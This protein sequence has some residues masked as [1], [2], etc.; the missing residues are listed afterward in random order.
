MAEAVFE[1]WAIVELFGHRRLAG[2][3]SEASLAGGKFVRLDVPGKDG[4]TAATQFYNPSAIYALTPT[5]EETAR[6]VAAMAQPAPVQQW[7]LPQLPARP[8][9]DDDRNGE[10]DATERDLDDDLDEPEA[11]AL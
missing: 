9:A 11:S 4:A 1:G 8:I 3:V 5:S 7:E 2:H 10:G 6:R